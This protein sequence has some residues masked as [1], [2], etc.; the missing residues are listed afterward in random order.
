M[1]EKAGIYIHVPFCLRKCPYCDF[2]SITDVSR[3]PDFLTALV[4][5]IQLRQEPDLA[6][7]TI[8]FGG[9]TPSLMDPGELEDILSALA[10]HFSIDRD[11]EVTLE[12][13]PGTLKHRYA[14][15]VKACGINR[16]SIGVQS[17]SDEKLGFLGRIH[18]ADDAG[19]AITEFQEAGVD[20]IGLDL[21]YG[22]PGETRQQ[23]KNDLDAA[24]AFHPGHLSCYMLT[25]EPGTPLQSSLEDQRFIPLDD[26]DVSD[27]FLMVSDYLESRGYTHYEISNFALGRGCR[28]RHNSKYWSGARYLGLGPGA[29]SFERFRRTWNHRSLDMYV[30]DTVLDRAPVAGTEELTCTDQQIEKVMLGLRTCEGIDIAGFESLSGR[31]FDRMFEPVIQLVE[32]SG[33]GR[34]SGGRFF[35]T[36][37]GMV[38]LDGI[39]R[40]LAEIIAP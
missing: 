10:G 39:V 6:V 31:P 3:K 24:L 38:F 30:E 7:D 29:H 2:F 40:R 4:R 13:N 15:A 5:E 22:L 11:A 1:S 32:R 18:T 17:F 37:Q 9:G 14:E 27:L 35:L 21:I 16:V 8:Y 26:G 20:A 25:Y 36:R 23:W 33:W 28:S 34:L 19:T 12:V